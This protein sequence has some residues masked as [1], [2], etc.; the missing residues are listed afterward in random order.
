MA[1]LIEANT[2]NYTTSRDVTVLAVYASQLGIERQVRAR[3]EVLL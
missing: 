3:L 2:E 1:H